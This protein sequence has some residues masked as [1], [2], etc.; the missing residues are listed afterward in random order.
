MCGLL[1]HGNPLQ[2]HARNADQRDSREQERGIGPI[3]PIAL[4]TML[5]LFLCYRGILCNV[6]K[7]WCPA[8]SCLS[9]V[10]YPHSPQVYVL[11]GKQFTTAATNNT[12]TMSPRTAMLPLSC[13]TMY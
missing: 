9:G 7:N 11:L 6:P 4:T 12:S 8:A 2:I 5:E 13:I 1:R 3:Y 10:L